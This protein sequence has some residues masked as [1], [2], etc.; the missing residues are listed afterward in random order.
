VYL[1]LVVFCRADGDGWVCGCLAMGRCNAKVVREG[2]VE[3]K[4]VAWR[5]RRDEMETTDA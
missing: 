5:W 2:I 4:V 1:V 3:M